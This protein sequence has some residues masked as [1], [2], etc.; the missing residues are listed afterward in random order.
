MPPVVRDQL[1]TPALGFQ[2]KRPRHVAWLPERKSNTSPSG[3]RYADGLANNASTRSCAGSGR[4]GE[5]ALVTFLCRFTGWYGLVCSIGLA[6]CCLKRFC[7]SRMAAA[8]AGWSRKS[9]NA[10]REERTGFRPRTGPRYGP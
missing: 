7:V 3:Y 9:Q 4:N 10:L 6:S 8:T 2:P 1:K 5:S